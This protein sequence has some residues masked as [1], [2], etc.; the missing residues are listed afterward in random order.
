MTTI[1][2]L[3]RD[4]EVQES[5]MDR[6][7]GWFSP[8]RGLERFRAKAQMAA[9]G[10]YSAGARDHRG[11]RNWV[12][13]ESSANVAISQDLR[14]L[15]VRSRDLVRNVPIAT[16]AIS[17]VVTNVV[18]DGLVLQS[19]ID[20]DVLG[21][22]HDEADLWQRK[23]QREFAIWAKRPDFTDRLNFDEMQALA[24][25]SVLEAGDLLVAR[26]RRQDPTDVYGLKL[27]LIE[28]DRL[29][30]P[31]LKPNTAT[32]VDGVQLDID[33]RPTGYSICNMHPGDWTAGA[34]RV[35]KTYEK[36]STV[37]GSPLI[38]HLY[39]QLRPDQARGVPYLAPVIATLK[40]LSD[41]S[42]AE[43][44]AA[45][46]SAMFT[47]FVKQPAIDDGSTTPLVGSNDSTM[48]VDPAKEVAL[49][50]GAI[51]DLAAGEDVSFADPKRP[52]TAYQA[53]VEATAKHIGVALELPYEV[54]LKSFT[55]S[56]SASRAALEM[57]WQFFRERRS[58]L[59]WKF[60][61]PVYEW[62]ITEAIVNGRLAAP[63]F[64]GDPVIREAWLG[65]EWIG[66]SRIQLDPQKE[67]SADMLDLNMGTKTR[68][69]IIMER[70]GGD[71]ESKHAQLTKE[72]TMRDDAGLS[73]D[74]SAS[75]ALQP[76][77]PDNSGNQNQ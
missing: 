65:S 59:A 74:N 34:G 10:G 50:D 54:L 1:K 27:Q 16:G 40:Q 45:V 20:R 36:G 57:A 15:R 77:P 24:L 72:K 62:V 28:A 70:T 47:V 5:V 30:N 2:V 3:G 31:G 33:G 43:I 38:L 67:A 6:V 52:N 11:L 4:V 17:T 37:T 26:R 13:Q 69:Q 58:W 51:I 39:K 19:L 73:T 61:Q 25:R 7:V 71:F 35:W 53:F 22:S 66:P 41:Y 48:N 9:F 23:A 49:G 46:I 32:M 44:R 76:A 60:C 18:G 21:L 14:T 42:E 8:A 63:G 29:S 12:T 64:F 75:A 55:A 56:Y 68:A